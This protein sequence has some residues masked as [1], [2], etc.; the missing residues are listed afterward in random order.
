MFIRPFC[1]DIGYKSLTIGHVSGVHVLT[2]ISKAL[3]YTVIVSDVK[4]K[5]QDV[6][7]DNSNVIKHAI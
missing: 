2:E 3:L 4:K 6:A 5:T 7:A 1:V